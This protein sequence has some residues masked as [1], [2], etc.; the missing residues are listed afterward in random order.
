M[1]RTSLVRT[2]ESSRQ[3]QVVAQASSGEQLLRLLA[4]PS[5]EFDILLLDLSLG[6]ASL[7]ISIDLIVQ[8]LKRQP[9][10]RI[11]VVTMHNEPDIVNAALQSGAL[12]YVS[13]ASSIDVLQEAIA[14]AHQGRRFLDPNLVEVIVVKRQRDD[15]AW[16]ADLTKREREVMARL[17]NGQRVSDIADAL[18]LSIKTVSTHKIRLMEKLDIKSNAD[19]IKMGISHG[20]N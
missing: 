8:V 4:Q 11:V 14:H 6:S 13:K 12:G 18:C 5:T 3:F 7:A 10:T 2:L 16:D 9:A 1:V 17:C 19:L 15:I 20:L